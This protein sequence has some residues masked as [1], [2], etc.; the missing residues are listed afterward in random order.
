[1]STAIIFLLGLALPPME[2]EPAF[3]DM[4]PR[5][6]IVVEDWEREANLQLLRYKA[7]RLVRSVQFP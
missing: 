6:V 5:P 2:P 3:P 4:F 1:M 7:P